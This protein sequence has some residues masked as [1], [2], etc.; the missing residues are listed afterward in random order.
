MK[1]LDFSFKIMLGLVLTLPILL[2]AFLLFKEVDMC[3]ETPSTG[4]I[5][6]PSAPTIPK[7]AM[8]WCMDPLTEEVGRYVQ[9]H[10]APDNIIEPFLTH[11]AYIC[12]MSD[13]SVDMSLSTPKNPDIRPGEFYMDE[14]DY[15]ITLFLIEHEVSDEFLRAVLTAYLKIAQ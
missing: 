2:V 7:E 8:L 10:E 5:V 12:G 14:E 1:I 3:T 4:V 11:H 13:R 15:H 9:E 6:G